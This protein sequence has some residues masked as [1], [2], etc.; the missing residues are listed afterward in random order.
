MLKKNQKTKTNV[1]AQLSWLCRLH[2]VTV[3]ST[4]LACAILAVVYSKAGNRGNMEQPGHWY[5]WK[6]PSSG[7]RAT[8]LTDAEVTT[9]LHSTTRQNKRSYVNGA[10]DVRQCTVINR[11]EQ[12]DGLEDRGQM[13]GRKCVKRG[14]W[15][16][17]SLRFIIKAHQQYIIIYIIYNVTSVNQSVHREAK[18][19]FFLCPTVESAGENFYSGPPKKIL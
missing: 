7:V 3:V 11:S 10:E 16:T 8:R 18:A 1:W 12:T 6:Q 5:Y 2:N 19:I 9:P 13:G 15:N 14:R 17:N 4:L